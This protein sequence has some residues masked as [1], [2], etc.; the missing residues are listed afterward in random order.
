MAIRARL[1]QTAAAFWLIF[2]SGAIAPIAADSFSSSPEMFEAAPPFA[3]PTG[4]PDLS[5]ERV[6][7]EFGSSV[8][9][10]RPEDTNSM[11]SS[12]PTIF[13][14]LLPIEAPSQTAAVDSVR[15]NVNVLLDPW[16]DAVA[17]STRL[18]RQPVAVERSGYAVVIN[19]QV[20]AFIERYTGS[21]RDVVGT[22]LDRSGRYLGMIRDVLRQHGLPEDL[23]FVAMIESGFNP[24]AVSRAGA[25]GLWQF[26]AGTARQYGLRVDQWVDERL[27]PEKSTTAAAAYLR[28][29]YKQFGSWALA[30]AAYNAGEVKVIQAIRAVG[31]TDF[32][33]LARTR[34]LQ[35]E[36]KE[37]VPAI[38]AA[39]VIGR[40][41]ARF[42]FEP[43]MPRV[44]VT[45]TVRVPAET[46]LSRISTRTGIPLE[47]LRSLNPVLIRE[48]TPPGGPYD[49]RVPG[50]S[51]GAV[52]AALTSPPP[53]V[54]ETGKPALRVAAATT[55]VTTREF[56][57]VRPRETVTAIARQHGVSVADVAR[58][59]HLN[60]QNII[61]P[62]ERLRVSAERV[63]MVE[64]RSQG[65]NPA[66]DK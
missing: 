9:A 16:A 59:N 51:R 52:V 22:W 10:T 38:H 21:R 42:G 58:W 65:G 2:A 15:V 12:E 57:V 47:T 26:M 28:D 7:R 11:N 56:H 31:S 18:W 25:K 19:A 3:D 29:L 64:R 63:R 20:Q 55:V 17:E 6:D 39:T 66:A 61:H 45:D 62:G 43:V 44:V 46:S 8:L 54:V 48:S 24:L 50:G 30:K 32:W 41:P 4:G 14:A 49:L 34:F 35:Q 23:A 1:T 37:F 27:D 33:T 5:V 53:K 60:Q 40:D 36:T 13:D